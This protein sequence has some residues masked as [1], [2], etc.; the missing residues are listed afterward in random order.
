MLSEEWAVLKDRVVLNV[1]PLPYGRGSCWALFG[2]EELADV[3]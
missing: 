2:G 1:G 3:F